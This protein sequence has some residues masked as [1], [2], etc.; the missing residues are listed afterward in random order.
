M[1][2]DFSEIIQNK[3]KD[4]KTLK[5]KLF[6]T[7]KELEKQLQKINEQINKLD[8][9]KPIKK[10]YTIIE[11]ERDNIKAWGAIITGLDN[12]YGFQRKFQS[13]RHVAHTSSKHS[14]YNYYIDVEEGQFIEVNNRKRREFYKLED[15]KFIKT[16]P[17][18]IKEYYEKIS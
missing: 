5:E 11:E 8:N 6:I 12:K 9:P 15:G 4:T 18:E 1:N 3:E 17:E 2:N 13:Y 7:K 16:T 14:Y 10:T